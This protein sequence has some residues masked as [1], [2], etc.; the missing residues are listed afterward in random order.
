MDLTNLKKDFAVTFDFYDRPPTPSPA[1]NVVDLA[2]KAF[3]L[4]P[5]NKPCWLETM[6]ALLQEMYDAHKFFGIFAHRN[7]ALVGLALASVKTF[8]Y[9]DP[10]FWL[11]ALCVD[12]SFHQKGIG[13]ALVER[14]VEAAR[15]RNLPSVR[16][17]TQAGSEAEK[18]YDVMGFEIVSA[19]GMNT[20][21]Q[22]MMLRL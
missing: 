22:I 5:W 10:Y 2:L 20:R 15:E 14:T 21:D 6:P 13:R 16:L 12:P 3:S 19:P 7:D 11:N 8:S 9:G 18:L 17:E 1:Q 4:P